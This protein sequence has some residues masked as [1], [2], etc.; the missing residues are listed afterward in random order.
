MRKNK[1]NR[2]TAAMAITAIAA[3]TACSDKWDDHYTDGGNTTAD[4]TVWEAIEAQADL[5]NFARVAKACGYDKILGGSQNMSVFAPTNNALSQQDADDL[6]SQYKAEKNNGVKD[7]DNK[8][9]KQFLKNHISLYRH[10]VSS[11]SND[12]ITMMN[13]KYAVLTSTSVGEMPL[14][15]SNILK[16]NGMLFTIDGKIPYYPNV[17]EYTEQDNDIDS[18][19]N[20]LKQY[21]S[22][23]FD[24]SQSVPGNIVDGKTEYLDSVTI[25]HNSLF[26]G[27]GYINREDSTYWMLAP[28]NSE[29]N[30]LTKEYENYFVYDRSMS[31]RDSLQYLNSR[32][33]LLGS[34]IFNVNENPDIENIDTIYSSLAGRRDMAKYMDYTDYHYYTYP[35]PSAPGGIFDGAETVELSN[36][37]VL[38]TSNFRI[39]KY[40]TFAQS[41]FIAAAYTTY[42]DTIL[43]AED[44]LT[45]RMVL[46][47]NQFYNKIS[48]NAFAEIIPENSG[49]NPQVT[50]KIPGLLSNMGYDIYAVFMPAIAY[51]PLANDEQ[52][53]PCRFLSYITYNDINGKPVTSRIPGTFETKRDVIDSVLILSD[54]KFPTCYMETKNYVKLRIQSAVG[55]S[56]TSKYSRTMRIAGFYIKPHREEGEAAKRTK[57]Q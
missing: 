3:M 4:G 43:N 24:P 34:G 45:I 21:N 26:S 50:F 55:N 9:L 18:V 5:S 30:R 17:Y 56:Q 57:E 20:F 51:D 25:F 40:Q 36:G 28:T 47:G 2:L 16:G 11:L 12:S 15:Q 49:V 52:R 54:Y 8:V 10:P 22:Y 39:D 14:K 41:N 31:K 42:Q 32:Y 13:G 1:I 37:R 38:K 7:D 46:P 19:Y 23:V 29:W 35:Y 33:Y 48:D 27:I 53:L 6:L 44:P